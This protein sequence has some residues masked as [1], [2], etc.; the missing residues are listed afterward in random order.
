MKSRLALIV[1]TE[2]SYTDQVGTH[3]QHA[4]PV[5]R[6]DGDPLDLTRR[7]RRTIGGLLTDPAT[8]GLLAACG[9]DLIQDDDEVR[10]RTRSLHHAIKH[11]W[12]SLDEAPPWT[13][14]HPLLSRERL[15]AALDS[16]GSLAASAPPE[17][18]MLR[19]KG[20]TELFLVRSPME[21]TAA[22]MDLQGIAKTL[23]AQVLRM[24]DEALQEVNL[25]R[26]LLRRTLV[27]L[28]QNA[29]TC[30]GAARLL[31]RASIVE[32]IPELKKALVHAETEDSRLELL[33][34]LM[35]LGDR[36]RSMATLRSIV[37]HG[38]AGA[39]RRAVALLDDVAGLE[40]VDSL[41]DML[42]IARLSE[43]IPIAGLLY[44]LGDLRAYRPLAD[45]LKGLNAESSP[46]LIELVLEELEMIGSKRFIATLRD[47]ALREKRS[48]F[49]GRARTLSDQLELNGCDEPTLRELLENAER[50]WGTHE[51]LKALESLEELL[52]LQSNHPRGLYL[53]ANYL[54]E[55]GDIAHALKVAQAAVAASPKDWRVQRLYG[56]LLWDKGSGS[57]ALE[58]YDRALKLEPTDPYTWYYKGYVLYRLERHQ[59]AL[60]CLDRA[61]SL[62]SDAA[63]FYNQKGFCLE[64]LDRH[65]EAARCYRRSLRITPGDLF[66]REYLGQALQACGELK[67]AL[68]CFDTVLASSPSREEALFRRASILSSLERWSESAATFSRY[69]KLRPES[70]NAWFNRGLCLRHMEAWSEASTC[71]ERAA[72]LRPSSVSARHQLDFCRRH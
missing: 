17:V 39:R 34:A 68:S 45:A 46:R 66:T 64:R 67:E 63:S 69:L 25:P 24:I 9:L 40:D 14:R 30:A 32:S 35:R 31:G 61:L 11:L 56:S 42:K 12:Q 70:F 33:G 57:D 21:P 41:H 2:C 47:Y 23:P 10:F 1:A 55:Q 72:H 5:F 38:S 29:Q 58:A 52:T 27:P 13:R 26:E 60:P 22:L 7:Q 20:H 6:G 19:A 71:F 36:E 37:V 48:W 16:V 49:K 18:A 50:A 62:K 15:H 44:R 43:R 54:K 8:R 53:K 65:D 28:L 51:R 4:L 3:A 59:E